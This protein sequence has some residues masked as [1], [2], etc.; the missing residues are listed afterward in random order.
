M[1]H[2]HVQDTPYDDIPYM[3]PEQLDR[4]ISPEERLQIEVTTRAAINSA[5]IGSLRDSGGGVIA[6]RHVS[7]NERWLTQLRT[8]ESSL[9][10][11]LKRTKKKTNCSQLLAKSVFQVHK[12]R[13]LIAEGELNRAARKL[14]Y[15]TEGLGACLTSPSIRASS[16]SVRQL[17]RDA[18]QKATEIILQMR[19]KAD[20]GNGGGGGGGGG[21]GRTPTGLSPG[22]GENAPPGRSTG[23]LGSPI[24][25]LAIDY[26]E[27]FAKVAG[28]TATITVDTS[29]GCRGS[30]VRSTVQYPSGIFS[31]QIRCPAG[32]MSGL[33]Q[34]FYLSSL[35]GNKDQDEIDFEFLGRNKTSV[36]TNYYVNGVGGHEAL[37][38]L[39]F[40]CSSGF[41]EYVIYWNDQQIVWQIDGQ[42]KR[43]V[44]RSKLGGGPYP[45]KPVF[46][47]SSV[48]DASPVLGGDWA[49]T[50][51]GKDVPY[52][53]QY[54]SFLVT[55]PAP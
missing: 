33:V 9:Y 28:N 37:V 32:D 3:T 19:N 21:Q 17:T 31:A 16:S 48:W 23:I 10:T 53:A 2:A 38:P 13:P 25:P 15:A 6:N 44:Q 42:V 54:R 45:T 43:V 24:Q 12:A 47:Y 39:G 7:Y 35:E 49:G 50:F 46:M 36:Q 1:S 40:D 34:S 52:N 26:C 4:D 27:T 22:S 5:R 18:M 30:R 55:S 11:A 29:T 14:D 8:I 41:H 20:G 51:N